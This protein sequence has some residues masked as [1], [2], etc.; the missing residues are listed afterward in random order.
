MGAPRRGVGGVPP[1]A[2]SGPLGIAGSA[3]VATKVA[4]E[5]RVAPKVAPGRPEWLRKW[6]LTLKK[7]VPESRTSECPEN[8]AVFFIVTRVDP[9]I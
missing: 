3:A 7:V 1:G 8:R 9:C 4:L 5:A 2:S 6:L